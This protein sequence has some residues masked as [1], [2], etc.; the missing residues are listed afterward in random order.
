MAPPPWPM[1]LKN[2]R[3]LPWTRVMPRGRGGASTE[4]AS[5]GGGVATA[6][7]QASSEIMGS[8]PHSY[9]IRRRLVAS[10]SHHL[11]HVELLCMPQPGVQALGVGSRID[12]VL[13]D[14]V[15][16]D[17]LGQLDLAGWLVKGSGHLGLAHL[18]ER[19]LARG[20]GRRI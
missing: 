19:K 4:T 15:L 12:H 17:G 8:R 13:G 6:R 9:E 18:D 11:H 1:T 2:G 16:V 10:S 7:R 20:R 14:A 5:D 3:R